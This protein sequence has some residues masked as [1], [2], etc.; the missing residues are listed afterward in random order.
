MKDGEWILYSRTSKHH[1]DLHAYFIASMKTF[2]MQ[3][4]SAV[5]GY[6][7]T[8]LC[9]GTEAEMRQMR[10]FVTKANGEV[11]YENAR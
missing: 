3:G 7:R 8:E 4:T 10:D 11:R 5:D 9:R 2:D 6:L 1:P